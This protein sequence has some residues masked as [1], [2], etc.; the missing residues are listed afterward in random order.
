MINDEYD[1]LT[2]KK[3]KSKKN[4]KDLLSQL[5]EIEN[6]SY[7][8]ES[9]SSASSFLPSSMLKESKKEKK[10]NSNYEDYD[11]DAWF[12]EMIASSNTKIDKG[13]KSKVDLFE[14]AGIW[15]KKKKKKKKGKKGEDLVDYKR[16]FEPEMSL[17]KNLLVDQNKFTASLQREYDAIKSTKSSS[18]GVSKQVTDLIS[19]I[20]SARALSMQLIEKNVNAKKL[21]AELSLKQR[22]EAGEFN[23]ESENMADFASNY[24]KQML[25]ERQTIVGNGTGENTVSEYT[26][27]ELF[28]ELNSSLGEDERDSDVNKYLEYE[29]RNV[30]VFVVITN[31]DVENYE[32]L[33]KDEN[34]EIIDDYTQ[35]NHT[36]IS[37]NRSTDIA[38]DL[39]GKKYRIIWN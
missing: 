12:N 3:G 2:S 20:T 21:I 26:E 13:A 33:A 9:S 18:R 19:N 6:D 37:V 15:G 34:G 14:S 30:E 11:P 38:T 22:K 8:I 10:K 7:T 32:F 24:L 23:S 27:D 36:N 29:N 1:V 16:E 17:Y 39:F 28:E 25:N 31:D 35:P 5:K 4:H